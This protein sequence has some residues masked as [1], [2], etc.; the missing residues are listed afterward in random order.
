[1]VETR[2]GD[3][4]AGG[5]SLPL[6]YSSFELIQHM[7]KTSKQKQKLEEMVPSR[8]LY[9]KEEDKEEWSCNPSP[10]IDTSRVCDEVLSHEEGCNSPQINNIFN[11]FP[12]GIS[13]HKG[14]IFLLG[15]VE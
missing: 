4:C 14:G 3:K 6:C 12:S 2:K 13:P 9:G 7:I 15:S 11:F 5:D 10:A 8:N 1:M